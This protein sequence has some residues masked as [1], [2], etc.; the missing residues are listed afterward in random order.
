MGTARAGRGPSVLRVVAL[1][2]ILVVALVGLF[3]PTTPMA[4]ADKLHL[5]EDIRAPG[6]SAPDGFVTSAGYV[7]FAADDGVHGIELWRTDG[8]APGT[9]LVMDIRPGP[10]GALSL[11]DGDRLA[12]IVGIGRRVFFMA[13]DGIHGAELWK[14]DGTPGGT[15]L[16]KDIH[17]GPTSSFLICESFCGFLTRVGR[18]LFFIADDGEHGAELWRSD[19]TRRGT[20]LVKDVCPGSPQCESWGYD[21]LTPVGRTLFFTAHNGQHGTELWK[22]DG[23]RQ[24]TRM[25]RDIG[26]GRSPTTLCGLHRFGERLVFIAHDGVHG[27][28]PWLSNGTRSGTRLLRDVIPGRLPV[29]TNCTEGGALDGW[30]YLSLGERVVGGEPR[31]NVELWRSDGTRRGTRKFK[32]LNRWGSSWPQEFLRARGLLY[33]LADDMRGTELWRTDGTSQGTHIL[34]DIQRGSRWEPWIVAKIGRLVLFAA[35]D[36]THGRELWRTNGS[37]RGTRMIAD[38]NPA[39]HFVAL[40]TEGSRLGGA[41]VFGAKDGTHGHEPWAYR[42]E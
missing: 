38:A 18:S 39:G 31:G 19:G 1:P 40:R 25:V 3:W 8:T 36:G 13:D 4:A 23:T 16:V 10:G 21:E 2:S 29:N 12:E 33:F 17:L 9:D 32:E 14:T 24:G 37:R 28:E 5:V 7:Y 11:D 34:K 41:V 22:S 30:F 42:A 35:D 15:R 26:P 20:K 27:Y 6:G